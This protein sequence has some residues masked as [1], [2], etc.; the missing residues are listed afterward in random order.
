MERTLDPI[1]LAGIE[2]SPPVILAPL[3][4]ITDYPFRALC[5]RLGAGL[6]VSEMVASQALVRRNRRTL[7]MVATAS[8]ESPLAVQIFGS[9]PEI[10]AEAARICCDHGAAIIDINM[11]CPQRKIVKTGA[12]AA[13]MRR[14]ELAARIVERV[15]AALPDQVPVTVKM[16]LGWDHGELTA[17]TLARMVE[18]VGAAMVTVHARTRSQMFAGEARWSLVREV[19][20]AVSI[21]VVV[22]GDIVDHVSLAEAISASQAHG[23][24]IGR[25]ALG[26]P[27]LFTQL[28]A[29]SRGKPIPEGP[30]PREVREMAVAHC[31]EIVE[32]Y[33][34]PT[35]LWMARKHLAWYSKGM[36]GSA[37]FR[38]TVFRATSMEE[39]EALATD[40]F[41]GL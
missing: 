18:E 32:F 10:M 16:R 8:K 6:T 39:L 35:G 24:M 36:R 2:I 23:A 34:L 15:R 28:R 40:Y 17:P 7:S 19:V 29:W 20:E 5:R 11:G 4:G 14:P 22:N 41:D 3:A 37:A 21:P 26:R 12:G 13:L 9:D 38:Q 27:W 31:R 30:T 1:V 25:G 33:G